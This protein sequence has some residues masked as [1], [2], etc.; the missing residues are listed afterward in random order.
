MRKN[1][2]VEMMTTMTTMC[3]GQYMC[4]DFDMFF[5]D[6]FSAKEVKNKTA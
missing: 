4:M 3:M 6:K 5:F 1:Y 2:T